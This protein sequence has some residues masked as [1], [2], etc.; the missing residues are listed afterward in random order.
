LTFGIKTKSALFPGKTLPC[1]LKSPDRSAQGGISVRLHLRSAS[2]EF[3]ILSR[4]PPPAI[5]LG[6]V[7]PSM[8]LGTGGVSGGEGGEGTTDGACNGGSGCPEVV[9][10][11]IA[12]LSSLSGA[13][14]E[15]EGGMALS[16]LFGGVLSSSLLAVGEVVLSVALSFVEGGVWTSTLLLPISS[17][18]VLLTVGF[19]SAP[20]LATGG[21]SAAGA[22]G[23]VTFVGPAEGGSESIELELS[24]NLELG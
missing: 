23:S 20:S 24:G 11:G 12:S 8:G 13:R 1:H 22:S 6:P 18:S 10:G 15:G 5:L 2:P 9:G 16:T 17:L 14:P 3:D 19:V 21:T 4:R 7:S